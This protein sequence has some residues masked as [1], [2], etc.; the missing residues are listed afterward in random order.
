[1]SVAPEAR[2]GVGFASDT[3]TEDADANGTSSFKMRAANLGLRLQSFTEAE[4]DDFE[5]HEHVQRGAFRTI[6]PRSKF[7]RR[8]VIGTTLF[9]FYCIA[10]VPFEAGFTWWHSPNGMKYFSYFLDA[11][12]WCDIIFNF[13]TGFV[14]HGLLVMDHSSI[15]KHYLESWFLVDV[16]GSIPFEYIFEETYTQGKLRKWSKVLKYAKLPK[17]LRVFR[18]MKFLQRYRQLYTSALSFIALIISI[19]IMAC[20]WVLALNP[21]DGYSHHGHHGVHHDDHGGNGTESYGYGSSYGAADGYGDDDH[22]RFLAGESD[23]DLAYECSNE[24]MP[25]MYAEAL[26]ISVVMI[27]G[28]SDSHVLIEESALML[29]IK[30]NLSQTSLAVIS[31][32]F[33]FAGFLLVTNFVAN[34]VTL[35]IV[36]N[37]SGSE[38]IRKMNRITSEMELHSVPHDLRE[39]VSMFYNY[40]WVH[41]RANANTVSLYSEPTMSPDLRRRIALSLCCHAVDHISFFAAI[42][43][44]I[45]GTICL[46][47]QTVV[48]LPEDCIIVKGEVGK[49]LFIINMGTAEVLVGDNDNISGKISK[50][51]SRDRDHSHSEAKKEDA[52]PEAAVPTR[53]R[54]DKAPATNVLLTTGAFFGEVA[55]VSDTRRTATVRAVTLCETLKLSRTVFDEIMLE[56]PD[57]AS[58]ICDLM[59]THHKDPL[60]ASKLAQKFDEKYGSKARDERI[61]RISKLQHTNKKST[62][63]KSGSKAGSKPHLMMQMKRR[64][65]SDPV[66]Q[67][68][69]ESFSEDDFTDDS[70]PVAPLGTP[71]KVS[72]NSPSGTPK[73]VSGSGTKSPLGGNNRRLTSFQMFDPTG[74]KS[75]EI[76]RRIHQQDSKLLATGALETTIDG[77]IDREEQAPKVD[78]EEHAVMGQTTK[79]SISE[80]SVTLAEILSCLQRLEE[81]QRRLENKI[82]AQIPPP[83]SPHRLEPLT[84]GLL[85]EGTRT[86]EIGQRD[87]FGR[88]AGIDVQHDHGAAGIRSG[89]EE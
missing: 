58:M 9:V 70:E 37:E 30:K 38:F 49:E 7:R 19:H 45:L 84:H 24:R 72:H 86:A 11:W 40:L 16:A 76:E 46:A 35:T 60:A 59:L 31:A 25:H 50:Q 8:W 63:F 34:L 51:I 15:A 82:D 64:L 61:H 44:R 21:C 12:F 42:P 23:D 28:V 85:S 13:N 47:L 74:A 73:G 5:A 56:V 52:P 83:K 4:D 41:Q 68:V 29:N 81:N 6:H 55:L 14:H 87:I 48:Y 80:Q 3:K 71:Q 75:S 89:H 67:S 53:K 22:H 1:M 17:L 65:S 43:D 33:M 79:G 62:M 26:H 20:T 69:S 27:L 57:F 10:V 2:K 18:C 54:G 32:M 78:N 36:R 88:N 77:V 66:K 39:Q